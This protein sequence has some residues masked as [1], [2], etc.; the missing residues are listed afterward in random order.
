MNVPGYGA[1]SERGSWQVHRLD[2]AAGA[3]RTWSPPPRIRPSP[4]ATEASPSS[5][6]PR[7]LWEKSPPTSG[8][9]CLVT[10][11]GPIRGTPNRHCGKIVS[12]L[13]RVRIPPPVRLAM[14]HI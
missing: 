8:R 12:N 10:V 7:K 3:P 1:A 11:R 5:R 14:K 2:G 9:L 4:S 13:V 6:I